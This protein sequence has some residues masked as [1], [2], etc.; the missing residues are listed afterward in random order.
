MNAVLNGRGW[1]LRVLDGWTTQSGVGEEVLVPPDNGPVLTISTSK[2]DGG[3]ND[4]DL[5]HLARNLIEDG[6]KPEQV[7]LGDF[8]GLAFAYIEDDFYWRHWY[9]RAGPLWLQVNYDCAV[10]DRGKHDAAID[11]LLRSLALDVGAI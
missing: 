7:K 11:K 6:R 10:A 3:L 9:L 1:K 5:R 8:D 4:G 2:I